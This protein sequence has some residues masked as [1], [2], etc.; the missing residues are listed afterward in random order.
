[1]ITKALLLLFLLAGSAFAW[2]D[3]SFPYRTQMNVSNGG[4]NLTDYQVN[5]TLNTQALVS[6]GKMR[7]DCGD[8]R[9]VASNDSTQLPYWIEGACN[10]TATK[11]WV[12][13]P[14]IPNGTS[15]IYAYYG[16]PSAANISNGTSTFLGFG[17][18]GTITTVNGKRIH[19][20]T[21]NGTFN[22]STSIPVDYLVVAGGGAGGGYG[23]GGGGGG[24]GGV[25]NGTN[26]TLSAQN[27]A[28][29]VGNGGNGLGQNGQNSTFST[30]TSVGGGSGAYYNGVYAGGGSW[31]AAKNGGSGGGGAGCTNGGT[32]TSGQGS[33]GGNPICGSS[34]PNG[35]G[36][37]ASSSGGNGIS[38][39]TP[40]NGGNGI[41]SLING[42]SVY[43]GGG[44][45]ASTSYSNLFGTG[46]IGGGG[47]AAST[48]Q[49]GMA[50]TGG[51]GGAGDNHGNTLNYGA[52]GSGIVIVS[53]V[54][55]QYASPEP[56]ASAGTEQQLDTTAP[57][58]QIQSPTSQ[59]YANA[60]VQVNFTATDNVG[61]SSCTV[62]LNGIVN[63]STCS[64]YTF[65]LANG[66]YTL[67]VT[68]SDASGN[69]NSTQVS[70]TVAVVTDTAP[71]VITIQSPANSTYTTGA[72]QVN[73]TATDN[74][75][76]SSCT[77]RLNGIVNSSACSNYTLTLS[78]GAYMLNVSANDTSGN[79]NSTQLSFTVTIH[80]GLQTNSTIATTDNNGIAA[81]NLSFAFTPG[82]LRINTGAQEQ[83]KAIRTSAGVNRI[84]VRA[85]I[86]LS[87]QAV[88]GKQITYTISE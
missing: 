7:S 70:F 60:S 86:T 15:T 37:G 27:Y 35:G 45:G 71:P 53:Y 42:S 75:G 20:F 18:G 44:G 57:S 76:V 59:T 1:M 40:G 31:V 56:T 12:K 82:T 11:T 50:N 55:R 2:W 8:L 23:Y 22:T 16:N 69:A 3:A 49:N 54:Y 64:N 13:M 5:I 6:A 79:A 61:V 87:G 36:G 24:G 62:R 4:S 39:S 74:V 58:V 63:S 9:I 19:T 29:V 52:G 73:F 66:A 38:P 30:I 68:A 80:P 21:S 41:E 17:T 67:N 47:N 77:V 10:T 14:L 33:S 85:K 34:Y 46:G 25:A 32:G 88:V 43:Y 84:Q 81:G 65:N 48:G 83:T 28:I 78:N 72:V 51:G 26:F